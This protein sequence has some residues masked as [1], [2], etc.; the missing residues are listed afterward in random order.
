MSDLTEAPDIGIAARSR[1]SKH[2][3]RSHS[4]K[5]E[6]RSSYAGTSWLKN[7]LPRFSSNSVRESGGESGDQPPIVQYKLTSKHTK[8]SG[9]ITIYSAITENKDAPF[10]TTLFEWSF[11]TS[12]LNLILIFMAIYTFLS[13][14]FA[15]LIMISHLITSECIMGPKQSSSNF[16]DAFSLS[17]ATFSTVGYG[18]IRPNTA[19]ELSDSASSF[20]CVYTNIVV[21][22]EAFIGILFAGFCGA[23][24]FTKTLK[25]QREAH[26]V[27]SDPVCIH[28][29]H[30]RNLT[31]NEKP[32]PVMEFRI[33]N[34]LSNKR[35]GEIV[36]A[37]VKC[38]MAIDSVKQSDAPQKMELHRS[39]LSVGTISKDFSCEVNEG[40]AQDNQSRSSSISDLESMRSEIESNSTLRGSAGSDIYSRKKKQ[41]SRL[42]SHLSWRKGKFKTMRFRSSPS[43]RRK[44]QIFGEAAIEGGKL[45]EHKSSFSDIKMDFDEHPF[46]SRV[47]VVSHSL[48]MNSP[49]LRDSV[50]AKIRD[51]NGSWPYTLNSPHSIRS[52]IKNFDRLIFSIHGTSNSSA[53]EV[54]SRKVYSFTDM[55][56]GYRFAE[57]TWIDSCGDLKVDFHMTNVV[58]G[59]EGGGCEPL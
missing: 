42:S 51:N 34:K 9:P 21:A 38:L 39:V 18:H 33:I 1:N 46:F 20:S 37:K 29:R 57:V 24:L 25:S 49:L 48:D 23:I 58:R 12:Y 56:I 32:C 3:P 27:F 31:E 26:V 5:S 15:M 40:G 22:F 36:D 47:W 28:F 8:D 10:L 13:I 11:Q 55:V 44:Q 35:G 7:G 2:F 16:L 52:A 43:L 19:V 30:S 53:S 41:L 54:F 50:K 14:F 45:L 4:F 17:W 6:L 59:Q